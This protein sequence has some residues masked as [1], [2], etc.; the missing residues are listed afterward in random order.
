MSKRRVGHGEG[1]KGRR[2]YMGGKNKYGMDMRETKIK[3]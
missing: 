2:V 1:E 3:G